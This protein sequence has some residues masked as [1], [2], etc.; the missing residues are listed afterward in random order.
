MALN[1][2]RKTWKNS[3]GMLRFQEWSYLLQQMVLTS[4]CLQTYRVP[5]PQM[6]LEHPVYVSKL[7]YSIAVMASVSFMFPSG[8]VVMAGISCW[9]DAH[10]LN[11]LR[12]KG[13]IYI[14]S[15]SFFFSFWVD[16]GDKIYSWS[17]KFCETSSCFNFTSFK[18]LVM[19]SYLVWIVRHVL[20][21]SSL[22]YDYW[23][24]LIIE[25]LA[26]TNI[27]C[28]LPI[29]IFIGL[30]WSVYDIMIHSFQAISDSCSSYLAPF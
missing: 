17:Q 27:N 23:F 2:V 26:V 30:E 14:F 11:R 21:N 8:I 10:I 28:K 15:E 12:I 20:R 4:W 22:V 6:V 18:V 5:S 13:N 16:V 9:S 25:K 29:D 1:R 19:T 3:I 7:K 24:L